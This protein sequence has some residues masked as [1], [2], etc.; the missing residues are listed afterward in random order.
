MCKRLPSC[1]IF[2]QQGERSFLSCLFLFIRAL[3]PIM[4]VPPLKSNYFPKS[5]LQIPSQWELGL[6]HINLAGGVQGTQNPVYSNDP[7]PSF[8]RKGPSLEFLFIY[9]SFTY[10]S[11]YLLSFSICNSIFFFPNGHSF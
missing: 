5:H 2:P 8:S 7:I 3:I 4:R 1:C 10:L 6:Q 9:F 11:T